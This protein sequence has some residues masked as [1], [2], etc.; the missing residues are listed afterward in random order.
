MMGRYIISGIRDAGDDTSR[1]P[2]KRANVP[3]C[4]SS[5]PVLARSGQ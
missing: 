3:R 2:E 4:G 1:K 5:D